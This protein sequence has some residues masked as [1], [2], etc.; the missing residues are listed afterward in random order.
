[1]I[2]DPFS[3]NNPPS[4]VKHDWDSMTF[5]D[6]VAMAQNDPAGFSRLSEQVIANYIN[7]IENPEQ[8]LK[9]QQAQFRLQSQLRKYKDPVARFNKMVSLFWQQVNEFVAVTKKV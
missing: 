5:E 7:G 1:M 3:L 6:K 8:K 9:M 2:I 4:T